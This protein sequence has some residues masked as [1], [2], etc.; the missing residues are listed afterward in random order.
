MDSHGF[1]VHALSVLIRAIR[2]IRV[3]EF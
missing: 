3:Q 2:M 1:L